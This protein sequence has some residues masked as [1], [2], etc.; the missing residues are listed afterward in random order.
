MSFGPPFLTSPVHEPLTAGWVNSRFSYDF[1]VGRWN[2]PKKHL[3][4]LRANTGIAG[5]RI[6][7]ILDE[8]KTD[9]DQS[10]YRQHHPDMHSPVLNPEEKAK[11]NRYG[12]AKDQR[13]PDGLR[14]LLGHRINPVP[15][16]CGQAV[17][18]HHCLLIEDLLLGGAG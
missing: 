6:L 2:C 7:H 14:Y 8:D 11:R 15:A 17:Y 1:S 13:H 10:R 4:S 3:E 16:R 12:S 9:R 5:K 18:A